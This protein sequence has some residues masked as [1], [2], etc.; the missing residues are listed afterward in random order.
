MF[1]P[2]RDDVPQV[3]FPAVTVALVAVS[4]AVFLYEMTLTPELLLQL[5]RTAG[6]VP[7]EIAH[8]HDLTD[9]VH[10]RDLVPPPLTIYTSLFLHGDPLHLFGNLWFLWL[11]GSRLEGLVG[12]LRFAAFYGLSATVAAA[13]QVAVAPNSTMPMIG[14]SGAISGLLGAYAV[15]FPRA[16]VRCLVFLLFFVTFVSLPASLLLGLWFLGQFAS[17]GGRSPGVA[18]FAHIGGF[19]GGVILAR[20][21]IPGTAPSRLLPSPSES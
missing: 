12:S 3:R 5:A 2:L 13:I 6:V 17:A 21:M 1:L 18:W 11:F 15:R 20:L 7:W 9:G 16:R 10:G 8:L 14:A 4:A 19:V